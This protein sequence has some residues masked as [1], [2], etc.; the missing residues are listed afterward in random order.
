M[1]HIVP[2]KS[3]NVTVLQH[4]DVKGPTSNSRIATSFMGYHRTMAAYLTI[5][6]ADGELSRMH[7]CPLLSIAANALEYL[8][9]PLFTIKIIIQ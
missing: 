7:V 5:P 4:N 9:V 3:R 8:E 2:P 1:Q 6:V